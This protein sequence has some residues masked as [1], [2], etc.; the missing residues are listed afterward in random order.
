MRVFA[1]LFHWHMGIDGSGSNILSIY[2]SHEK[3][4]EA[5]ERYERDHPLS[6]EYYDIEYLGI[7]EYNLDE[8]S[9]FG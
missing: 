6:S 1:L 2:S 7:E 3:A 9:W 8:E 5:L 4:Q